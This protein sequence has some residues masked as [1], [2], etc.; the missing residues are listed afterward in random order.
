M[1]QSRTRLCWTVVVIHSADTSREH[2]TSGKQC[3]CNPTIK[4]VLNLPR[5]RKR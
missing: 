4:R 5:R 2:D 1:R 3:W